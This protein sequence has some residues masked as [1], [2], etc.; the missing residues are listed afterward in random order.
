MRSLWL[1]LGL[2]GALLASTPARAQFANRS[3]GLSVGFY[4]LTA[5]NLDWAIPIA[6]DGSIYIENGFEATASLDFMLLTQPCAAGP[7]QVIGLSPMLGF[8][9]LF[10][11]ETIRPY[12]GLDLAYLHIF[13]LTAVSDYIG[14]SPKVGCDF[15]TS[16]NFS[17][18]IVGRATFYW[19][20]N[21]PLNTAV[22]LQVK[23]SV[24]F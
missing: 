15:F 18:G 9:Y 8:R 6:L 21:Q 13:G 3:L 20:L 7:C 23:A 19:I 12:I 14:A 10:L 24:Y 11:E 17:L 5:N 4:K 22:G 1:A 2:G 16:E